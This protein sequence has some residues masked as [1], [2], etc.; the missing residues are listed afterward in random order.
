MRVT[1][2]DAAVPPARTTHTHTRAH[3][4]TQGWRQGTHGHARTHAHARARAHT[5][6]HGWPSEPRALYAS[7]T[8]FFIANCRLVT[9]SD[10]F[11]AK[12]V[13][14]KE[15]KKAGMPDALEKPLTAST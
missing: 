6:T 8:F 14:M 4:H 10:A 2:P 11:D 5:H 3:A 13:T 7:P 12:G 1:C 9:S 15:T